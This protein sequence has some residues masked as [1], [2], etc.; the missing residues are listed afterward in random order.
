VLNINKTI[1]IGVKKM[2]TQKIVKI[3]KPRT[4]SPVENVKLFKPCKLNKNRKTNKK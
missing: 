3:N 4:L 2:T 1:N